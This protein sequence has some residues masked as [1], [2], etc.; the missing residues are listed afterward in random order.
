VFTFERSITIDQPIET[1]FEY[2]ADPHH[3]AALWPGLAEI[4]NVKP[5]P[6]GGYSFGHVCSMF[7]LRYE[8]VGQVVEF[9]PSTRIVYKFTGNPEG[10]F[11]FTFEPVGNATKVSLAAAGTFPAPLLNKLPEPVIKEI[12]VRVIDYMLANL[13]SVLPYFATTP[14][15]R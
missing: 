12:V 1:V 2:I 10:T 6:A 5:Q 7:G 3:L 15:L 13:K 11:T 8:G 9:V 4:K 14:A